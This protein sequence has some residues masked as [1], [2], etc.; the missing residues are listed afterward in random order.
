MEIYA[1]NINKFNNIIQYNHLLSF[2]DPYKQ[3]IIRKY[4]KK[5]D[6][7]RNLFV[8]LTI[9]HVLISKFNFKNSDIVFLTNKYGKPFLSKKSNLHFNLSHSGVWIICVINNSPVGIDIEE[10]KLI[11]FHNISKHFYSNEEHFDLLSK[12]DDSIRLHY[13][14]DLWTLKE[15]YVKY[16][17]EGLNYSLNKFTIKFLNNN[18]IKIKIKNN[19]IDSVFFKQYPIDKKY[20]MAVCA[21][22]NNFPQRISFLSIGKMTTD[23]T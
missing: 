5:E 1:L 7:Y 16:I 9:R 2:V 4:R 17:G 19:Y 20:K 12:T 10:I 14:Y 6:A 22:C 23:F 8:E 15:S 18:I 21:P 13:F 11:D 3:S